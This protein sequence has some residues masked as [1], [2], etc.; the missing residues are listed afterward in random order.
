M[1]VKVFEKVVAGLYV[2]VVVQVTWQLRNL[3]GHL[4]PDYQPPAR[5]PARLIYQSVRIDESMFAR[6]GVLE[7]TSAEVF[8]TAGG[9][10]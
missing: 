3:T 1:R 7:S 10:L 2:K 5:H 9:T 8:P 4:Q 6:T